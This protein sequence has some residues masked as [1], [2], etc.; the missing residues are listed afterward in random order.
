MNDPVDQMSERIFLMTLAGLETLSVALGDR[1][2][3]YRSLASE[4]A[5]AQVLADRLDTDPRWTREWLEQQATMGLL[6]TTGE[7]AVFRLA[8]GVTE[9]LAQPEALTTLAPMARMVAASAA[10]L[11]GIE[12]AA[13]TGGGLPWSAYGAEMREAQA[14]INKPALLQLLAQS[15]LPTAL[16][17]EISRLAAGESLKAADIGC[18]GGWSS[19]GLAREFPSLQIDAYDVDPATVDLARR[20][21]NDAGLGAQVR[22]LSADLAAETPSTPYDFAVAVECI[23]DMPD[24]VGVLAGVRKALRPTARML[25]VDEKVAEAFTPNGDEVERVMYAYSTLICLPD[26]MSSPD[27]AA[28]GTVMRASTLTAYALEAGFASVSIADVEHDVFRFY[29]LESS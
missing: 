24:P 17:A 8:P 7:P 21:V 3:F 6:E 15:W 19:I 25:V 22:V 11:D 20:N 2:G 23:H 29:V 13:R 14:A 26:G 28:T 5:T 1:L 16:P 4:P 27:S 12:S 18:G 9:T 10:Q